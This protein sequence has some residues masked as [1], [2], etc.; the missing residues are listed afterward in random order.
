M[1]RLWARCKSDGGFR[2]W[3]CRM[4]WRKN[5]GELPLE[6]IKQRVQGVRMK[7][8]Y[9]NGMVTTAKEIRFH[10]GNPVT[11]VEN[12]R[13]RN[14]I[15]IQVLQNLDDRGN[16]DVDIGGAGIDDMHQQVGLTQ[17]FQSRAKRSH[18]FLR[19]ISDKTDGVRDDDLPIPRESQSAA[20]GIERFK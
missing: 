8:R 16:L 1:K 10:L 19:Q 14:H 11:F 7:G 4:I 2:L 9:S 13:P 3:W 20:G 12:E 15:Q 5:E 6:L 18:E 17:F